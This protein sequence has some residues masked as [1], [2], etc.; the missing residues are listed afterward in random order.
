MTLPPISAFF[1]AP[2]ALAAVPRWV[3]RHHD[4]SFPWFLSSLPLTLQGL[5]EGVSWGPAGLCRFRCR[6]RGLL[7]V[8]LCTTLY[9]T[10]HPRI[11]VGLPLGHCS[12]ARRL[13]KWVSPRWMEFSGG[14]SWEIE[15]FL[16]SQ[17]PKSRPCP[18]RMLS[19]DGNTACTYVF[20]EVNWD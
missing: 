6:V 17:L 20:H 4:L 11:S 19:V 9:P 18:E 13:C 2:P 15:G 10:M 7:K 14:G 1:M 16:H 5:V 12:R 3:T 8:V